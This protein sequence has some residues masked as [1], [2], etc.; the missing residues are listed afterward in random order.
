MKL[1]KALMKESRLL[2]K[3]A[4]APLFVL[5]L[6][7]SVITEFMIFPILSQIW[8]WT[9]MTTPEGFISNANILKALLYSPWIIPIGA[10]LIILFGAVTMWQVYATFF[11]L[12]YIFKGQNFKIIELLRLSAK[13]AYLAM[14][15]KNWMMFLYILV[16]IPFANV[17]QATEMIGAFVV[18]EY[19]QDF[20]DSNPWLLAFYLLL[21]LFAIYLVRRW[22]FILPVFILEKKSFKEASKES[23]AR[24]HKSGTKIAINLGIYT[25]LEVIRLSVL[26]FAL[27]LVASGLFL[28][29]VEGMPLSLELTLN[30]SLPFA[31][32][33]A[34]QIAG[35]LVYVSIMCFLFM[36]YVSVKDDDLDRIIDAMPTLQKEGKR[37]RSIWRLELLWSLVCMVLIACLYYGSVFLA[38][39][40]PN[41]LLNIYDKTDI[42]AHKGYSS[43]AP[44]NTMPAFELADQC[45]NADMM[46]LDVWN[47]KDGIPVVVH[48]AT[49]A[50]ATGIDKPVYECTY[51]ELQKLPAPYGM[52]A[53]K[54]V[55]A[56]IP[57]LEEVIAKYAATTPI[58]IEIK[59]YQKDN[60][61]A[62]RIVELMEKYHC[63]DTSMIHSGDYEA[64]RAV[65][66]LNPDIKC[67]LIQA[68]VSGNSF[69]LP[70]AD[71]LS[72]EHT[73]VNANMISQLHK[74]GKKLYVWT[75]NYDESASELAGLD[76]DGLITD[77]P[78]KIAE[79]VADN[80]QIVNNLMN[81]K[82]SEEEM[83][84]AVS[85]F[86]KGEY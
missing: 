48:N 17:F 15:P 69:D 40:A 58:L 59:G 3:N 37:G 13:E 11:A 9:L 61:L 83:R 41:S 52:D 39:F 78:D 85:D 70:Y 16:I 44:E 22:F 31:N 79:Y 14:R 46:E 54:F 10:C 43:E 6:A 47:S 12:G 28:Y 25:V 71:F 45:K 62:N 27:L 50:A 60:A 75:V 72:V 66:M 68:I 63:T 51:D 73:F 1:Q 23:M 7:F 21:V 57:S 77:Y 42:V 76:V 81:A 20:I 4:G 29:S 5:S 33:F 18:P 32:E 36:S 19:I 30:I 49:I 74:R 24:T 56:R 34:Q 67:G 55:D 26:P 2:L 35:T 53:Q 8:E 64:L 84:D 82:K 86:E 65:K 80:N 38:K